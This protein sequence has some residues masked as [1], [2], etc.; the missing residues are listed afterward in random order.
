MTEPTAPPRP[1]QVTLAAWLIMLGSV[2]VVLSVF[3]RI[4]GLHT[5]ETQQ[6]VEQFL[7]DSPGSGLGLGVQGV[8]DLIRTLAMVAGGFATAAA[9]LGYQVL[10]RSRSARLALSILA[11]PLFVSGMVAGGFMSSVVVASAVMLW[12][13]P[14]RD[15]FDG[16]TPEPKPEATRA[17]RSDAVAPPAPRTQARPVVGFGSAAADPLAAS[18]WPTESAPAVAGSRPSAVTRACVLT[19]IGAG[20][21]VVVMV[22]SLAVLAGNPDLIIDEMY[23]QNPDFADQGVTDSMILG[24]TY[25]LGGLVIAWSLLAVALAVLAFRRV[26]W[27]RIALVVSASMAAFLFLLAMITQLLMVLPLAACLLTVA[28]LLRPETRA[29]YR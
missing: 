29:W 22:A 9:I 15:W 27:A 26:N 11:L 16:V 8:L 23:R 20:L 21:A 10:Q 6:S 1:R 18:G 19:W 28:L 25:V 13:Q 7:N 4:S 24:V 5:L 12:F 2:F 17:V 14:A 3:E